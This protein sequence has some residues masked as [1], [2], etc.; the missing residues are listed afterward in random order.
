MDRDRVR[1]VER[2]AQVKAS[3]VLKTDDDEIGRLQISRR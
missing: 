2:P 3:T 1:W